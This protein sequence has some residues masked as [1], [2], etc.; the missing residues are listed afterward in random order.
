MFKLETPQEKGRQF[1]KEIYELLSKTKF[2][3][4]NEIDI[5]KKYKFITAIDHL[6]LC[7]NNMYCFQD[8]WTSKSISNT[9][10]NHFISGIEQLKIKLKYYNYKY[11]G[12]YLSKTNL[13]T[14]AI[15]IVNEYNKNNLIIYITDNNI[16]SIKY[17]LINYLY[18]NY[19]YLYDNEND[20]IM[21]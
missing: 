6:L 18:D 13:S 14:N 21:I 10:I 2:Q 4:F 5:R 7:N 8:K 20:V 16:E 3:V 15:E 11:I 9:Q 19:I 12:I 1:E 17:K